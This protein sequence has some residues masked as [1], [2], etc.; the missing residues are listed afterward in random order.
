MISIPQGNEV[1]VLLQ[2][3]DGATDQHPQAEIRDD[4]ANLLTT[5]D[6]NHQ[7]SG[8]YVPASGYN[9]PNEDFIKITYI[10]Y[11]DAGHTTESAIYLRSIDV[12]Y[13]IDPDDYKAAGFAT[14]NPP[15]QNL[16]D[17][18]ADVSG[19]T[20]NM[21]Y[22]MKIIKNKK[23]L[24]KTGSVWHLII[25]DDNGTTEILNKEI[26][27]VDGNEITDLAAGILAQELMNNV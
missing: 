9:M 19:I 13:R 23:V 20:T 24:E 11:T 27:D 7:A 17:Y 5:L 10:V 16:D 2:I 6:L 21:T 26:K 18:K 14:Q 15:S 12:F 22:M 4:E 25:Y 1:P 8:V 3:A